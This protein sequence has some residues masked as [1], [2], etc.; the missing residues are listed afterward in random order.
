MLFDGRVRRPIAVASLGILLV[1]LFV[2]SSAYPSVVK[3]APTDWYKFA[4]NPTLNGS[5]NGFASVFYDSGVYHLYCS[6]GSI[7]HFTSS[8]GKTGWTADPLNPMLSGNNEGVPMVWKEGEIG[9]ASCRE[10]V[11]RLV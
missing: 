2:F 7:L 11:Y 10:R 5:Q 8:D 9:R 1:S 4:G 3:A 6:W